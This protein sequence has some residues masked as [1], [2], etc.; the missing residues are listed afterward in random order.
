M[1]IQGQPLTGLQSDVCDVTVLTVLSYPHSTTV[2]LP[3]FYILLVVMVCLTIAAATQHFSKR[4]QGVGRHV[5]GRKV[6]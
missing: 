5:H 1:G 2:I 4:S 3:S 6:S